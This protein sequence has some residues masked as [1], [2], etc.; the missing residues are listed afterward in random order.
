MGL[1]YSRDWWY[2][3]CDKALATLPG[4]PKLFND[5]LVQTPT[6]E[7]LL[8]RIQ[9]V[10]QQCHQHG[11]ILSKKKLKIGQEVSFVSH[12]VGADGICPDPVG[13]D[14]ISNYPTPTDITALRSFLGL[15][16]HLGTY[17]PNLAAASTKLRVPLFKNVYWVCI[18]E[19]DNEFITLKELL[20]FATIVK[21][22]DQS[23]RSVILTDATAAGP[24]STWPR[25][26]PQAHLQL[27][28]PQPSGEEIRPGGAGGA[29]SGLCH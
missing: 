22:F 19:H 4:V 24:R 7:E 14:T 20:T 5:I 8:L 2:Q 26:C 3:R 6:K 29:R 28:E 25:R 12:I 11:M 16:N 13:L 10:W 1:S 21:H 9:Q 15:A 18:P 27:P 17:L 23:L